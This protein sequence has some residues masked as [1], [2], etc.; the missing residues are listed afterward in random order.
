MPI[1][2][3]VPNL[4]NLTIN[5]IKEA[6]IKITSRIE[7]EAKKNSPVDTGFYRNNIKAGNGEVVAN[8]EYSKAVEYGFPAGYKTK[9][10]TYKKGRRP[11]P[12]MRNSARKVQKEVDSI[13]AKIINRK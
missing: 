10:F 8:A 12:V 2:V 5:G 4:E 1:E 11:N 7:A 13:V 3:N 9:T 6:V